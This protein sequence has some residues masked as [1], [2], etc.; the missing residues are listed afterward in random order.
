MENPT[1]QATVIPQSA[2]NLTEEEAGKQS[3]RFWLLL[4]GPVQSYTSNS[5]CRKFK[6][7]GLSM[8]YDSESLGMLVKNAGVIV[9][10]GSVDHS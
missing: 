8:M 3:L 6:I 10:R 9:S 7:L 1:G 4:N 2:W 5:D